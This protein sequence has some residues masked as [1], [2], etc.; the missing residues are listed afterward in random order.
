LAGAY[1]ILVLGGDH[2]G[3]TFALPEEGEVFLGRHSSC[4]VRILDSDVSRHHARMVKKFSTWFIEPVSQ[5]AGTF[6]E[7]LAIDGPHVLHHT[8]KIRIGNTLIEFQVEDGDDDVFDVN[9][10]SND[11]TLE[12][13][14]ILEVDEGIDDDDSFDE[15]DDELLGQ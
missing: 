15:D 6:L 14:D 3:E 1:T 11:D 9:Q 13:D 10:F 2:S 7:T 5:S 4:F 12:Q 8:D